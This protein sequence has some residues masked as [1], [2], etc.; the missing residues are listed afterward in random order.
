MR[1]TPASLTMLF[2]LFALGATSVFAVQRHKPSY[3]PTRTVKTIPTI[4]RSVPTTTRPKNADSGANA[5]MRLGAKNDSKWLVKNT[6]MPNETSVL[7]AQVNYSFIPG[8][9]ET[10][11]N[12]CCRAAQDSF[13]IDFDST[14]FYFAGLSNIQNFGNGFLRVQKKFL[15]WKDVAISNNVTKL[16]KEMDS[17]NF[18][19]RMVVGSTAYKLTVFFVVKK[20]PFDRIAYNVEFRKVESDQFN[21]ALPNAKT[22]TFFR[23]NEAGLSKLIE[24][25]APKSAYDKLQALKET[26]A[27]DKRKE[28]LFH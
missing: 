18:P 10:V 20:T 3:L 22:E 19:A 13:S 6:F 27:E 4:T 11:Q 8:R 25:L 7:G 5:P 28:E 17:A 9:P 15:E 2:V 26:A 14:V 23:L 1:Y 24:F 16:E 12:L 21:V